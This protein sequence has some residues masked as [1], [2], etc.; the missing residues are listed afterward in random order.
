[1][2]FTRS[3]L[4]VVVRHCYARLPRFQLRVHCIENSKHYSLQVVSLRRVS[5][6][7]YRSDIQVAK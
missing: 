3:S 6:R 1:M 4:A 2:N 5:L 7:Y